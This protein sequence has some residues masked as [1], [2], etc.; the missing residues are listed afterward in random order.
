MWQLAYR[1][2]GIWGDLGGWVEDRTWIRILYTIPAL[3]GR[4]GRRPAE[5]RLLHQISLDNDHRQV[6]VAALLGAPEVW[7]RPVEVREAVRS[8][9][10][11]V[12]Q[13]QQQSTL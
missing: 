5:K 13:E 1:L 12:K 8:P 2:L 3:S 11:E 4:D 9:G 10:H 6:N 7:A